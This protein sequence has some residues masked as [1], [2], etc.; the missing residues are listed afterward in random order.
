[1]NLERGDTNNL[2]GK[3]WL[4]SE[5]Y[6]KKSTNRLARYSSSNRDMMIVELLSYKKYKIGHCNN[7]SGNIKFF[8]TEFP[9][10]PEYIDILESQSDVIISTRADI[11]SDENTVQKLYEYFESYFKQRKNKQ[12][13]LGTNETFKIEKLFEFYHQIRRNLEIDNTKELCIS[14]NSLV[15]YV[16]RTKP[17]KHIS[18]NI[19]H[20]TKISSTPFLPTNERIVGTDILINLISKTFIEDYTS[21]AQ[22][23]KQ[24]DTWS[25]SLK[26]KLS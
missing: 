26:S 18:T 25:Y 22:L 16:T 19:E 8:Y 15:N 12:N 1:M 7:E 20:L 11:I 17:N 5:N 13:Y 3:V 21:A 24:L 4:L 14:I 10:P 2:L 9:T 23:K 6:Q